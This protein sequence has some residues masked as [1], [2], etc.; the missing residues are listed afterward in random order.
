[1]LPGQR[2]PAPATPFTE[3]QVVPA[4]KKTFCMALLVLP[5]GRSNQAVILLAP[6]L[7]G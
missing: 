6:R 4:G 5:S 3:S 1:M 7:V 2:K